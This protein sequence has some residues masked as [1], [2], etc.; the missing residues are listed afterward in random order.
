[1]HPGGDA[2]SEAGR[3]G[4]DHGVSPS[5]GHGRDAVVAL[6]HLAGKVAA[7]GGVRAPGKPGHENIQSR[8]GS[9]IAGWIPRRGN[10]GG[11]QPWGFV[12]APTI[13]KISV[14]VLPVG[15]EA[16]SAVADASV[17]T[18]G[19]IVSAHYGDEDGL[20]ASASQATC[21]SHQ[22][23]STYSDHGR[24]HETVPWR[25]SCQILRTCSP[26]KKPPSGPSL[27][28]FASSTGST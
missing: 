1:M 9:A 3:T 11:V 8:R 28:R 24:D 7:A 20:G 6:W 18:A 25:K 22:R 19:G 23:C 10:A 2:R 27:I 21:N 17:R 14:R 26:S 5:L 16:V 15:M 4:Q 12:V 13:G